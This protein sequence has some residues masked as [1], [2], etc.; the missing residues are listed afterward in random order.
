MV[1][2]A[3]IDPA[4]RKQDCDAPQSQAKMDAAIGRDENTGGAA[5]RLTEDSTAFVP[6]PTASGILMR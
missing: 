5:G 2:G 4:C 1:G 3:E 6:E